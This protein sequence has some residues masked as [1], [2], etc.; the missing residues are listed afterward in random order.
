MAVP[1]TVALADGDS[2]HERA[3]VAL[4]GGNIAPLSLILERV[5]RL[6]EGRV[7]EV[8]LEDED[9]E[10]DPDAAPGYI[11]EI[12]QLTPQGNVLK[13]EMDASTMKLLRVKGRGAERAKKEQDQ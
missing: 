4:E 8:E 1:V 5:E 9:D 11:Y 13:L 7:I 2:D 12:K 3:R 10:G 6:Y